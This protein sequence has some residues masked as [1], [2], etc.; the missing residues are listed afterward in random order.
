MAIGN[1]P[2]PKSK[3]IHYTIGYEVVLETVNICLLAFSYG[4]VWPI[5]SGSMHLSSV[6]VDIITTIHELMIL[7][8]IFYAFIKILAHTYADWN[9]P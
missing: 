3:N 6:V 2:R 9:S 8:Y 4:V 5:A 1:R 7:F